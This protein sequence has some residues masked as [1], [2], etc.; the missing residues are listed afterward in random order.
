[1]I[2][3]NE[4]LHDIIREAQA[5]NETLGVSYLS[6]LGMAI[7]ALRRQANLTQTQLS[8]QTGLS[9]SS[10][11]RIELGESEATASQLDA[12]A[13]ALNTK[14]SAIFDAADE[15][16][17]YLSRENVSVPM[18]M[19]KTAKNAALGAGVAVAAGALFGPLGLLAG[20]IIGAALA[21]RKKE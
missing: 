14:V 7:G 9:Q 3:N 17:A 8:E 11:S 21:N 13:S 18:K 6:L 15:A 20:S 10:L 19:D 5:N 1:M 2:N 12:I 16:R 4:Y